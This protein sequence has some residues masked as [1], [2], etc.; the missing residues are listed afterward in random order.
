MLSE[1]EGEAVEAGEAGVDGCSFMLF[2]PP[3]TKKV[4]IN[5]IPKNINNNLITKSCPGGAFGG[6][7]W[8]FEFNFNRFSFDSVIVFYIKRKRKLL[9]HICYSYCGKYYG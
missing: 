3:G 7:F 8:C 5:Q 1:L 6:F 9:A 4:T 2:L